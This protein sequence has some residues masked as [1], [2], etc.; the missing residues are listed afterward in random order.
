MGGEI[1]YSNDNTKDNED[2]D[3]THAADQQHDRE[4]YWVMCG[5]AQSG[6]NGAGHDLDLNEF[7]DNVF[8][9]DGLWIN[10]PDDVVSGSV[11]QKRKRVIES[12]SSVPPQ[13]K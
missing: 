13:E 5:M 9:E 11:S 3:T 1:A 7:F 8:V 12:D 2:I 4:L 6:E 10:I